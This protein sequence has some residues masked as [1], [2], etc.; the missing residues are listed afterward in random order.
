MKLPKLDVTALTISPTS[1][2]AIEQQNVAK[3]K[4]TE[5]ALLPESEA[6]M[7]SLEVRRLELEVEYLNDKV[8]QAEIEAAARKAEAARQG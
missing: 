4:P 8:K 5:L 1:S 2:R 7:T 6:R 3:G